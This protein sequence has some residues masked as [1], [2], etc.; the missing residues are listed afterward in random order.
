MINNIKKYKRIVIIVVGIS[1][2]VMLSFFFY[3][4][5]QIPGLRNDVDAAVLKNYRQKLKQNPYD[6]ELL[7]RSAR[8]H[9]YLVRDRLINGSD[10]SFSAPKF[11]KQALQNYRRVET[12]QPGSLSRKDYFFNAYLYY[13]LS[14]LL[15]GHGASEAYLKRARTMALKSHELGYRSRELTALLGNLHYETGEYKVALD[16]YRSLGEQTSDPQ[17]LFNRAWI[18]RETGDLKRAQQLMKRAIQSLSPDDHQKQIEFQLALA[19][20]EIDR[21]RYQSAIERIQSLPDYQN[22]SHARTVYARALIGLGMDREAQQI[23][24]ELKSNPDAP[25]EVRQLLD[26]LG[27][28]TDL[29]GS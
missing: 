26:T 29:T 15:S 25:R 6:S 20:I 4:K 11:I 21:E 27:S 8:H 18:H 5:N 1:L 16:Y 14:R 12:I 23:L 3:S 24:E 19:R 2:F 22:N 13:Q 17:V 7:L 28:E 10:S 9:Y